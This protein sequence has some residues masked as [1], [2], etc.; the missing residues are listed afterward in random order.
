M[1][2]CILD[3]TLMPHLPSSLASDASEVNFAMSAGWSS[4][5]FP[6]SPG[7]SRRFPDDVALMLFSTDIA[8][9]EPIGGAGRPELVSTLPRPVEDRPV[10]IESMELILL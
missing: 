10:D 6:E 7:L 8:T 1:P 2:E 3:V 5:A 4:G 9:G